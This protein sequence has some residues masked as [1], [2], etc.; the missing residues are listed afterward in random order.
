MTKKC[1]IS[2]LICVAFSAIMLV[3]MHLM[4][5]ADV[6]K[7]VGVGVGGGI[8]LLNGI[9]AFIFR[10]KFINIYILFA[11]AVGCGLAISSLYIYLGYVP[12]IWQSAA[13]LAVFSAV[14]VIY[15]LIVNVEAIKYHPVI[16]LI[17]YLLLLL[18]PLIICAAVINNFPFSL[19]LL[20]FV[21][22]AS[23]LIT[24]AMRA[25]DVK[26]HL[27]NITC[28]S[29]VALVIVIIVVL[30]VISEGEIAD[31][32]DFPIGGGGGT[33]KKKHNPYDFISTYDAS[34]PY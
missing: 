23:F 2:F 8:L 21:P 34:I 16:S 25:K 14:F 9:L 10:K 27:F 18:V 22:F 20:A 31:G 24:T 4:L 33:L 29:F 1:L 32:L 6:N 13:I 11:N 19:A 15:C 30:I 26:A 17:T 12:Q 5:L 3:S 7:Y 28:T